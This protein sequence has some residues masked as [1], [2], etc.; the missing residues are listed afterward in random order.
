M[1]IRAGAASIVLAAMS[2]FAPTTYAAAAAQA[3]SRFDL[4]PQDLGASL[5]AVAKKTGRQ[6]IIATGAVEGKTAPALRGVF[7]ADD[8]VSFLVSGS[9]VIVRFTAEAALVGGQLPNGTSPDG[10]V[11]K[12]EII[13]TGSRIRGA[14]VASPVITLSAESIRNSGQTSV[15]EAIASLP[16]AFSGGINANVGIGVPA[17]SGDNVNGASTINLRGLGSD[18]TLTLLNGHRLANTI[19]SQSIDIGTIPLAAVDRIEI[20]ADGASALYGSDAVAGV[21][22]IRLK[23]DYDG[24]A[25]SA[26]YGFASDGGDRQQQYTAVAGKTW[27][28]GGVIVAGEYE[29]DTSI[30]ASD[31][32]YTVDRSPGLTLL[33]AERH[34][35]FLLSG[36]QDLGSSMTFRVDALY[37]G[38]KSVQTI[39]FG[40][41]GNYFNF[42][43]RNVARTRNYAIAP[44]LDV[45]LPRDWLVTI[46]GT[47]SQDKARYDAPVYFDGRI[48]S[49]T[50]GCYCNRA[51]SVELDGDGDLFAL[52]AGEVKLALGAG[53][54]RNDFHA[55]R[56]EGA[57]QD[58]Q[59]SQTSYF[60][61]GEVSVPL[62]SPDL[63]IP[64]IQRATLSSALRYERYPGIGSVLTPKFGALIS[65]SD[66][67]ELK[68]SWG[69]SF[70]APT[71][72]ERFGQQYAAID[73]AS[74]Y[75][76]AGYPTAASIIEISGGNPDLKPER[77]TTWSTTVVLH[78]IDLPGARLELSYFNVH[79]KDR[80]VSP[81]TYPT[82]A[83]IAPIYAN[84]VNF[85]PTDAQKAAA[86]AGRTVFDYLSVEYDPADVVAIIN[87]SN[88]NAE[89]QFIHGIDALA[90]YRIPISASSVTV[91]ADASYLH[92]TE[93]LGPG[94]SMLQLAGTLFNPPHIRSRVGA[95]WE[96]GQATVSSYVN[97]IGSV[98]DTRTTPS[99]RI[100]AM[101]TW[102]LAIR[103]TLGEGAS[104]AKG[105]SL[106]LSAENLLNAKPKTIS[107]DVSYETPYDSTNYSPRGR[108][109]SFTIAK[110]L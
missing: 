103:Y 56:T 3:T 72:Y 87:N 108:F 29:N 90:T 49:P 19:Y 58:I 20:V 47:I 21:A 91:T 96:S 93:K 9:G 28:G 81:V 26:R 44:S 24:A 15:A 107:T 52:P 1:K 27:S 35:N 71:L 79:Y 78:P 74:N 104:F 65:P 33:P 70:K 85:S 43:E 41:D 5:R 75:G 2:S 80:V 60:G 89:S 83:L 73:A 32:S 8:A 12:G 99:P 88:I 94:Q 45:H 76:G 92:S 51:S 10:S 67:F 102:D 59:A 22:N 63:V 97:Y 11:A 62:V 69:R 64:F 57:L 38:R 50:V 77:A 18:A 55:Y 105:L 39:A 31:R 37:N 110:S 48:V 30:M 4:P 17:G 46:S 106:A 53:Y 23:Q 95:L 61:Y 16:Q 66:D 68:G 86:Q 6:I 98:R 42:G 82:E 84:L 34:D 7:S 101:T 109:L 40:E 25:V 36:H 100:R 54:R 14:V 13:V